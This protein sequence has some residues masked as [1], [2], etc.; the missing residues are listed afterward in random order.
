[1]VGYWASSRT[2]PVPKCHLVGIL[3]RPIHGAMSE[4]LA[5]PIRF[6]CDARGPSAHGILE[7]L[8]AQHRQLSRAPLREA[9]VDIQFEQSFPIEAIDEFLSGIESSFPKKSDIWEAMIGLNGIDG[10]SVRSPAVAVGRRVDSTDGLYVLQCKLNGF[11]LSR[12]TPYGKWGD[13][14]DHAMQLWRSFSERVGA[15]HVTRIAVRYI[16]QIKLP[17]PFGDFAEYLTCPP[18]IPD[19]VPQ[20]LSE[21]ITRVVI[22]DPEHNCVSIVTQALEGPPMESPAGM[23]VSILLDIDVFQITRIDPGDREKIWV[24]L[25]ELRDQKNRMFFAHLTEKTVELFA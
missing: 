9:L 23:E 14:R 4:P 2:P 7:R 22:P 19:A 5:C 6:T 20:A 17:L 18:R 15:L 11:T 12:L 3:S 21:F 24:V 8:V 1:M 16:N 25:D 10:A 13:L